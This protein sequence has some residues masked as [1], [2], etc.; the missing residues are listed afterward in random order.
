MIRNT[1]GQSTLIGPLELIADGSAVTSGAAISTRIAGSTA[2]GAGTLAHVAGGVWEYA[3]TQAETDTPALGLILE[4]TGARS[5]GLSIETTRLP[6]Q[7]APG[8]ANG[9]PVLD[10]SAHL[11][12]YSVAQPVTAGTVNDKTGYSLADS[13]LTG[14]VIGASFVTVIQSGLATAAN[15]G[16]LLSA[17]GTP[18]QAGQVPANFTPGLFASAGVFSAGALANTP[19]GSGGGSDPWATPIPGSYPAGS[20]GALLGRAATYPVASSVGPAGFTLAA[21]DGNAGSDLA[22][23]QVTILGAGSGGGQSALIG[24]S[25]PATDAQTLAGGSWP[26]GEPT[27]SVAYA[28]TPP[29]VDKA[30]YSLAAGSITS[31]TF[32]LGSANAGS[33]G[34]LERLM[35]LVARYFPAGGGSVTC[36]KSGNGTLVVKGASGAT[37]STQ[38]VS[39]DGTTQTLGPAS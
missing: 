31:G 37:L 26:R 1:A 24:S 21:D 14:S 7:T 18:A 34:L 19:A 11:L 32:Q 10:N 36:P 15:Q 38:P 2:A 13:S 5:V 27:G 8:S 12:A 28:L 29:D 3:P 30:G 22:G 17:I 16:T 25:D 33:P 9:L 4:A 23:W 6:V 35:L 20:A 39:D